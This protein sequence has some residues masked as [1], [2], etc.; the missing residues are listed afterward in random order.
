MSS[1]YGTVN[2]CPSTIGPCPGQSAEAN[3]SSSVP[4]CTLTGGPCGSSVLLSAGAFSFR[5]NL[6]SISAINGVSWSFGLDYL[7]GNGINDI[8]GIGFNYTQNLRLVPISG[9]VQLASGGN[10]LDTF[11]TTDGG[12]T[13]TADEYNCTQAELTRG[14]SGATDMFTL[15]ASDGTVSTFAG[16][17]VG[18]TTPGRLLSVKDRYGNTQT[19]SWTN[20]AG[21]SQLTSITDSYGRVINFSYYGAEFNYCLQQITDFLGRQLNIQYDGL[22]HL[23]AVVTPSIN[24]GAT[25]NT[26]PGGTAYVFQYDVDNPRPQRQNDLIKIFYPNQATPFIDA[27]SRTVDVAAVYASATPRY[28]VTYGQDPTDA[29]SWGLVTQETIGD[30][31][32]GVGGTYQYMYNNSPIVDNLID[33]GDHIVFEC[34]VTDRNGNQVVYDFNAAQMPVRV[35][36]LRN[37]NKISLPSSPDSYVT[38]MSYNNQN[39]PLEQV[40]PEGNSTEW[41]YENGVISG[42]SGVYNRRV[43]LLLRRTQYPS[44]SHSI[45]NPHDRSGS[46][47]QSQLTE[48]FFHDP[49]FNQLCA[50]IERRGLPIDDSSDYFA[51]QNG[52]TTPTNADRSRYAT[53]IYYDYQ[54]NQDSTIQ[55]AGA[56]A[57]GISTAE[58][59]SLLD[60]VSGQMSA[61][62]GTGGIPAGFE[63]GLGDINGDGTGDGASSDLTATKMLGSVVKIK[64][65]SVTQFAD[66]VPSV[67]REE[68]FTNNYQGQSTTHTDPN[69]N[70]TVWVRYPYNDPEGNGG[71]L[72]PESTIA[73]GNQYGRVKEIHVD[74]DPND[75]L[76]LIG[77]DGD[78]TDFISPPPTD[79]NIVRPTT[80]PPPLDLV[81]RFEGGSGA[82]GSGCAACAY[83]AL[84]NPLAVTNPRG[85]TIRFDRNELGEV[86]RTIAPQ[87]Y[88]FLTENYYDANRNSVR[89]DTQ[90]QQP[91]YDSADPTSARFA[92]FTPSGSGNTAH[93]AMRPGPGGSVRP[94]WF[95][96]LYTFDILDNKTQEDIDA[97]G[98]TPANLV[99]T[100]LRDANENVVQIIKPQGNIVE[101]DYDERD[102]QI[103]IRVGRDAASDEP[104]AVTVI[105]R[106]GNGNVIQVISPVTNGSSTGNEQSVTIEDA[107]RSAT[108]L[109]Y[110]GVFALENTLDGFDRVIQAT[111]PL[112]NYID[113]GVG[114]TGDNAFLDP[115]GRVIQSDN[116]APGTPPVKLASAQFRFDEGGRQY[117]AQRNVFVAANVTLTPDQTIW[118][119]DTGCLATNSTTTRSD[120]AIEIYPTR[121][122][123]YVLTR[124]IFDP[125]GRV[126]T[127]LADNSS[128]TNF[129]YDGADRRTLITDALGNTVANT[130]DAAGN[131]I[132]VVRTEKY[133]VSTTPPLATESFDT[134]AYYDCLDQIVLQASQGADG[135]LNSNVMGIAASLSFWQMAPWNV[136]SST[137]ISCT[138]RDSRG[139]QVLS[140]DA[141]GNSV[142][143]VVD[144]ASRAIQFQQH[145]RQLGQGQNPPAPG[146]TL[147]PASAGAIVTTLILDGNSR[148]TQLIDD[149]GN[150]TRWEFDTLDR[151]TAMIFHDGSTRTSQYDEASDVVVYIDENSTRFNNTFD[152]LSRKVTVNIVI[153][154]GSS[155]SPTTVLQQFQYDGLS[156]TTYGHNEGALSANPSDVNLYY[157]SIDRVLEDSQTFGG[158]TRNVT[159][160]VFTSYPVATLTY[161]NGRQIGNVYDNLYRR[162]YVEES[163]EPEVIALWNFFGPSRVAGFELANGLVCTMMNNAATNSAVQSG[164]PNPPW[165]A[166][167][168]GQTAD[169]LGY[170]GAGRMI[171]KRYIN[172]VGSPADLA[173]VGFTTA[174]DR[175]SNK[176][177]ERALH[178]EE[179]SSLY[180]QY[181]ANQIPMGG[182]D[183]LNRLLQYQRGMLSA[184][185]GDAG[186][187]GGSI[188]TAITLVGTDQ[189]RNYALDSLGNWRNTSFT[190]VTGSGPSAQAEV[191]QH[192]GL[193]EITRI[194]NTLATPSLIIPSYD[195][196]G[197]LLSDGLRAM[198]WDA[199]NRLVQV[200]RVSDSEAIG[201]YTY[202]AL[203]RRIRKV[204][205]N[206]GLSG[207]VPNGTTDFIY[208][209]WRCLEDRNPFGGE[210][211]STDTP[212]AQYVWGMYLD[213]LL[214]ITT[215]VPI[216]T[217]SGETAKT[218]AAGA[219]YPLQDLLYRAAAT[220]DSSG[221]IAEAYDVDA[222]G[223]TLIFNAAGTDS[224]WWADNAVQVSNSLCQFLFTGQ[225]FDAETWLYYY[226]R[227]YFLPSYGRFLS[228]DP[229]FIGRPLVARA[230][231]RSNL[232]R[233][234]DQASERWPKRHP[235][236][237]GPDVNPYRYCGNTPTNFTDQNG[238]SP[239]PQDL[240]PVGGSPLRGPDD[241]SASSSSSTSSSSD[242]YSYNPPPPTGPKPIH[243]GTTPA[244][245]EALDIIADANIWNDKSPGSSL[246]PYY[247]CEEQATRNMQWLKSAKTPW[248]YW[249]FKVISRYYGWVW[250]GTFGPVSIANAV[251][252]YPATKANTEEPFVIY[253]WKVP[254]GPSPVEVRTFKEWCKLHRGNLAPRQP[255]EVRDPLDPDQ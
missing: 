92:Q 30:P 71:I 144:G 191:R 203:N 32:N 193:N 84:G 173:I 160:A 212:N 54:K 133:S 69:G 65:P 42:I 99:T 247:W 141:K 86:Y 209:G 8:L 100:F 105:A 72:V 218:Y 85:F 75:V 155:V 124:N 185:G 45:P 207:T 189:V 240:G 120:G 41:A 204:V 57:L 61:T 187:G 122:Q 35:E 162:W 147:L 27:A 48:L 254:S 251:L 77:S 87:P 202:D 181:D 109:N 226:K 252:V 5:L 16:F 184:T 126:V 114:Y 1:Y 44:N 91:A 22:G 56:A 241:G 229:E 70:L 190:A 33:P 9:G 148:Q 248:K 26:F 67:Y 19:Y 211:G 117:E 225:R 149:R 175:A 131:L 205:S 112:G 127:A 18:V 63:Y 15:S 6:L 50:T 140:I 96:N 176:F 101:M 94:G 231:V 194:G 28:V 39:Q 111:D 13:Y 216:T 150:V 157:D 80:E 253:P 34:V 139:N 195:L 128:A 180:E 183:S 59:Q 90:D 224:N 239:V 235:F 250:G 7:A 119:D 24:Q 174:F 168:A 169:R 179:R 164:V 25:G 11:I 152:A 159:N 46:S 223:N 115:D 83:D 93:V 14:G 17:D 10:T 132:V 158:N 156:R 249:K 217:G 3:A 146:Q 52:G 110:T 219:Y 210:E 243:T 102:F 73:G 31:A 113:T 200:D 192:N 170:D 103:A 20:T 118:H 62:D 58:V 66:P 125:G 23:V 74:A 199:L 135:N 40:H 167:P 197:N 222:Y 255:G 21:T 177:Y 51:P 107:F 55:A 142:V 98:S 182:Y 238:K 129:Q 165:V 233:W 82:S 97:T 196:N 29:D 79:S 172:P 106:D 154:L 53:I 213:E 206:G 188:A 136:A 236:G 163:T 88:N 68:V 4:A 43:G 138:A 130:F 145:L 137:L 171:A 227:R 242:P 123:S 151:E 76:S 121:G 49:I 104:G 230:G 47:G 237:L 201:A 215:L 221:N 134:A 78:L 153:P 38:W 244:G 214:Q 178:A 116:Y 108:T 143:T 37:R 81:T 234:N 89:V 186:N 208:S 232:N 12:V 64:H 161:P 245:S 36:V 220:T 166:P 246:F 228:R 60:F 95:T 2:F 198:T